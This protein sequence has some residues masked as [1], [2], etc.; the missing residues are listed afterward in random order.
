M[1]KLIHI[2]DDLVD[3]LLVLS[4]VLVLCVGLYFIYD[5]AYVFENAAASRISFRFTKSEQAAEERQY[6]DDYVARLCID[7]TGI[8]YPV[9]QGENNSEYVNK[10]PYGNYSLTGSIF[11]DSRNSADFSDSYNLLY[12]HHMEANLMFGTLDKY[13]DSNYL[14]QHRTGRLTVGDT[15]YLLTVFAV[16]HTDAREETI[17]DPKGSE[18]V[19]KLARD[20]ALSF[21][22]PEND[23]VLALSTCVDDRSTSR[24]VV[25][26][27]M[28][29]EAM[30]NESN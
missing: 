1:L 14:E 25:L 3:R 22:E 17:F 12:G 6:T 9:M 20:S 29:K 11:L 18:A 30:A 2:V 4:F 27:T 23:H 24:T 21:F 16:L 19:I 26:L 10:D 15:E 13:Y 8:D 5:T 7:D 28:K